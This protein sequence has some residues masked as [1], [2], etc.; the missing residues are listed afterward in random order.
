MRTLV[1]V[2]LVL[3]LAYAA[4]KANVCYQDTPKNSPAVAASTVNNMTKKK[5]IFQKQKKIQKIAIA[6]F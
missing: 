4:P 6:L 2:A 3:A 5:N 1:V